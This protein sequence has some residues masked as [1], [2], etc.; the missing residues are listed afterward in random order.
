MLIN[1]YIPLINKKILKY[2]PLYK[3]MDDTNFGEPFAAESGQ[4][5]TWGKSPRFK[6]IYKL[7]TQ[8]TGQSGPCLSRLL[9]LPIQ[10][11]QNG[12]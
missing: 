4:D 11:H 3:D 5:G 9:K 6:K 10:M 2:L 7:I 1:A 12:Q 8:T